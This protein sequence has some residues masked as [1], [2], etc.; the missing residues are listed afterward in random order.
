MLGNCIPCG[1]RLALEPTGELICPE[2]QYCVVWLTLPPD[3]SWAALS[4]PCD[5]SDPASAGP[6]A[7]HPKNVTRAGC[8]R[9]GDFMC[10]LC[11]TRIQGRDYC[12][13]C[14]TLLCERG[15]L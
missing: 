12:P 1:S 6:C 7:R 8:D 11:W 9:C 5:P 10:G 3:A 15:E 14:F 4:A 13:D 2:C